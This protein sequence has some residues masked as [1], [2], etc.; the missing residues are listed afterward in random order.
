MDEGSEESIKM[1]T[2]ET[3]LNNH[4]LELSSTEWDQFVAGVKNAHIFQST[5][6]ARYKETQGWLPHFCYVR[7]KGQLKAVALVL[8]KRIRPF[9]I[10]SICYVPRGPI[11]D[12]NDER[13]SEWLSKLL[14]RIKQ[15]MRRVGGVMLKISPDVEA[16]KAWVRETLIKERFIP[17]PIPVQHQ[18]T[19]RL[20]LTQDLDTLE[21][22]FESRVRYT[23]KKTRKSPFMLDITNGSRQIEIFYQLYTQTMERVCLIPKTLSEIHQMHQILASSKASYVFI[24]FYRRAPVAGAVLLAFG[25]RLWYLYGGS[26][27]SKESS[28]AGVR[29]HWEIIRWAKT[30][31]FHEYDLQGVPCG[32]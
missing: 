26:T 5:L 1:G 16:N 30:K 8:I 7:E 13:A 17:S 20:D 27:R 10:G 18:C 25:G 19:F 12:Y 3:L 21:G 29:L 11:I 15:V 14:N 4:C 2:E 9:P 24:L 28:G 31:G 22:K 32:L 23:L 6:W